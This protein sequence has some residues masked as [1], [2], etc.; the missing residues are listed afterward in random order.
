MQVVR[1]NPF[2]DLQKMEQELDKL[3]GSDWSLAPSFIDTS[4]LDMY[5]EDGKFVAEISLPGFTKDEVKVTTNNGV[6]EVSAD[7]K[8]KA[9]EHD[10]RHYLLRESRNQCYR[11]VR[12]PEDAVAGKSE[13]SFDQG[14]LKITMPMVPGKAATAI[15]VT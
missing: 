8:E 14:V 4:T 15:K 3:W 12:L 2:R 11:H 1:Y 5:E 10:K 6:L 9:E 13:A 7:H